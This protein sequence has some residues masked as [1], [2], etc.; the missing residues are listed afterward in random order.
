ML[1]LEVLEE[2]AVRLSVEISG[3]VEVGRQRT[4]EPAPY[5]LVTPAEG[6]P[7]LLVARQDENNVS[8]RHFRLAPLP[9]GGALLSNFSPVPLI[10][11]ESDEAGTAV[12]PNASVERAPPFTLSLFGRSIRARPAPGG[13]GE[14]HS[15]AGRTIGP[16]S[17]PRATLAPPTLAGADLGP[18]IGYLQQAVGVLQKS[19][20]SVDFLEQAVEA[21]VDIVGLHTARVLLVE[22]D[23]WAVAASHPKEAAPGWW[24]SARVL[25]RVRREKRTFWLEVGDAG[26]DSLQGVQTVVAAP[27]LSADEQVIGALY[28][29]RHLE[30]KGEVGPVGK[31][32]ALLVDLLASGVATGLARQ[33][34]ERAALA[35]QARF[36][37]FFTPS[38]AR[39]LARQPDLLEGREAEVTVLFADVHGFSRFSERLGPADTVRW[40][41]D[42]LGEL[43]GLALAE[44]G[45]LVDY[46]G[47]EMMALWG[48]PEAQPDHAERAVRAALAFVAALP[49]L[50]E[51]WAGVLGTP[52]DLGIGVCT[53]PAY[54]GNTGSR[55][56]F[57][58]GPLGSTVNIASRVQGLTKYLKCQALV[59]AST[60]ARLG[61]AFS[62]R[63]VCRARLVNIAG[64]V[65]VY[66]VEP[67]GDEL[68]GLIFQ[69]TEE[70]LAALE[71]GDFGK[72]VVLAGAALQLHPSD[73][74][75]RLTLARASQMLVEEGQAAWC[76]VWS[77]PGK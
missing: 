2:G 39:H 62:A 56:K 6:P 10:F 11:E 73:G 44:G 15:L 59:T 38:L 55:H 31:L 9:G 18:L 67:P 69:R 24:P 36:E 51:R 7:R 64:P 29:E 21:M 13:P 8:R 17:G 71:E 3:P 33:E 28:G 16:G 34:Q 19:T 37:Q 49:K 14:M 61:P 41:G 46:I 76:P 60:R 5:V 65:D 53:G 27:L 23:D 4:G 47:D 35:A 54:V 57:K 32:E 22:G 45:V 70:A 50:N 52:M 12:P 72:A 1:I 42:V 48:A 26:G 25:G 30:R 63:R 66:A 77:P 20:G 75:L 68:R 43:S 58:Y 74:P 40:V